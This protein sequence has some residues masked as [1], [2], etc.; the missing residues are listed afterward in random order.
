VAEQKHSGLEKNYRV[1]VH[2]LPLS[3][4]MPDI[5]LWNTHPKVYLAIE[6]TGFAVCPYCGA[7]FEL[8]KDA[9]SARTN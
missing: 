4:P 1:T 7:H 2:D 6:A 9:S 5:P 3:C 8:I